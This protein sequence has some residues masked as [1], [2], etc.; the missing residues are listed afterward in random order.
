LVD[1]ARSARLEL[2]IVILILAEIVIGAVTL[3]RP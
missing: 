1:T 3:F 2:L